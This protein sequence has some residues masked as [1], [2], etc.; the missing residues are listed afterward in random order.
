MQIKCIGNITISSIL[1][2]NLYLNGIIVSDNLFHLLNSSQYYGYR[3]TTGIFMKIGGTLSKQEFEN[4]KL[5]NNKDILLSEISETLSYEDYLKIRE[6]TTASLKKISSIDKENLQYKTYFILDT[7]EN[8]KLHIIGQYVNRNN[9]YPIKIDDCGIFLQDNYKDRDVVLQAG[10]IR[11]R[12]SICGSNCISGCSFCNFGKGAKNYIENTLNTE[13]KEYLTHLIKEST[14]K[15]NVQT[16]F[17]TGGNPS[18]ADM[19]KWTEF[20][21]ES[22]CTFKKSVPDG[23]VDIML[24]PRGFDKYV[25]DDTNRYKEYKKY[26]E[27]LKSI[28]V[29]TISPNIEL[30]EQ[31]D[32]DKFCSV[33]NTGLNVGTT[34][35]EIGHNGYMDF[36]KAGIDVF[37]KFNVRTS[38]IVGLN[39]NSNVRKAINNL[40]P[41][42]CYV[43]ISPFKVPSKHFNQLE[44]SDYD[45]IELGNY[46]KYETD[47][48]MSSFPVNLTQIYKERISNSLNAHNSH[49]T[50][51]LCYGQDLDFI[52]QQALSLE[53][54]NHIVNN[55]SM[56]K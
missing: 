29:N 54:D 51:N 6:Y 9:I 1:K 21:Q 42:G 43:V 28:G 53:K 17:I 16:L 37:G 50:A 48:V 49:N 47:K 13:K 8:G 4:L 38:L 39:S 22:I 45:L 24:T 32:L 7:D 10:G 2:N 41:L 33:N 40:I 20:V 15:G 36:I 18:L 26:L 14:L 44:P 19:S 5:N 52:E 27:Y 56:I 3:T 46:L 35:S 25:Y 31:E 34:K 12:D 30:W 11:L 55:I 23:S